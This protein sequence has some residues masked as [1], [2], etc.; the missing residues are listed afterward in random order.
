MIIVHQMAK[1]ASM[2]WVE[3][4]RG[5]G[6]EPEHTHFVT[7]RNLQT[8]ASILETSPEED[9]IVNPLMV[10]TILRKGRRAGTSIEAARELGQPIRVITG[11][12]DPVARSVSILSFFADFCGHR[13]RPLNARDG[14]SAD[15]VCAALTELWQW[16]LTDTAPA[17][18]FERLMWHLIGTY[19]T[20]FTEE[21]QGVFHVDVFRDPGFPVA[22]GAQRLHG[23]DVEVLIYRAEDMLPQAPA[24]GALLA[25]AQQFLGLPALAV[26]QINTAETRRSY[27]LYLETRERFRLPLQMLEQIYGL[28]VIT[29]FYS[30]AEIASFKSR[31]QLSSPVTRLSG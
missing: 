22:Q 7:E 3:A 21:L 10:R 13:H 26:P 30:P 5:G 1:V 23:R 28:P 27:P 6:A 12:R 25:A 24:R 17:G 31:W 9:T 29:H 2:A 19:R 4:T 8:I 20:W 18:T 15:A 16:V 14:A 11:M